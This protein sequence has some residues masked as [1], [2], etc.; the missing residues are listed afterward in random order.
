MDA[1]VVAIDR[2]DFVRGV[3]PALGIVQAPRVRGP[4]VTRI[5][6]LLA[7]EILAEERLHVLIEVVHGARPELELVGKPFSASALSLLGQ[8]PDIMEIQNGCPLVIA[9]QRII[10]PGAQ[11]RSE[12][13]VF[14]DYPRAELLPESLLLFALNSVHCPEDH[15]V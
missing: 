6:Q 3:R 10:P 7:A 11:R 14:F 1:A 13:A 8:F 4:P 2:H 9:R 12:R 15:T 5:D